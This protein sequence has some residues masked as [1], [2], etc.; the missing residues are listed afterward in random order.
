MYLNSREY[1]CHLFP[2]LFANAEN[3][4]WQWRAFL[5]QLHSNVQCRYEPQPAVWFERILYDTP[6][7]TFTAANMKLRVRVYADYLKCTHKIA[8]H[9][10]YSIA[11]APMD[12]VDHAAKI[13][14]EENIHAYHAMF[15][16]QATSIQ[17]TGSLFSQVQHWTRI[18]R[19]TAGIADPYEQ[20]IAGPSLFIIRRRGLYFK[21]KELEVKTLLDLKYADPDHTRLAKVEFS[22]KYREPDEAYQP[23]IIRLMRQFYQMIHQSAWVDLAVD[24]TKCQRDAG[25]NHYHLS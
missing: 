5:G 24:L 9:D 22:W 6:H 23:H 14:F 8:S 1:Q 20:L 16:K 13:K 21:F 15:V 10:R 11:N 18:F 3:G 7:N 25:L 19:N 2:S 12:C 17:K 4:F